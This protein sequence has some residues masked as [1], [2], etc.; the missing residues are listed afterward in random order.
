LFEAYRKR[1]GRDPTRYFAIGDAEVIVDR[2]AAY[3]EAGISKFIL[4]PAAKG[5]AE[6]LAQTRRLVEE[7]LPLVA[8]RWPRAKKRLAAE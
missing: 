7:V 5:D 1:T 3:V 6:M 4:R 2:I 8:G